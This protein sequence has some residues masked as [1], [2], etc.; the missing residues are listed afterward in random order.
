M[1]ELAGNASEFVFDATSAVCA[2]LA[3]THNWRDCFVNIAVYPQHVTLVFGYGAALE[4]PAGMLRG[5]GKQV[6]HLRL[7]SEETL[8]DPY[9]VSLVRQA[10]AQAQR[11]DAPVAPIKMVKVYE[12]PKRRPTR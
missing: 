8:H 6:R 7:T 1:Q 11:P 12:G 5:G 2:G 9:V 3:L 4:D 10:A